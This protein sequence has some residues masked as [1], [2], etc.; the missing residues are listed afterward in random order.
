MDRRGAPPGVFAAHA[1]R[2]L[3]ELVR[4]I[5]ASLDDRASASERAQG[6]LRRMSEQGFCEDDDFPCNRARPAPLV[7][8]RRQGQPLS[9]ALV[10]M[11]L[12]RRLDIPLVGVNFPGR[13][14]LRVRSRPSARPGHRT[15]PLSH[16]LPRTAAALQGPKSELQAAYLKQASPGKILQRLSRN[17]RQLHSAAGERCRAEGCPAV[18]ELGPVGAADHEARA[19]LYRPTG[20]PA[21]GTLRPGARALA[22]D[23]PTEATAPRPAPGELARRRAAPCTEAAQASRPRPCPRTAWSDGHPSLR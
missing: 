8:Q 7:L 14:L 21:G 19:G 3:D 23:D 2:E 5:G 10:A 6:L 13:F 12:A 9:L 4:Q 18:I 1:L 11:E 20:L 16:R 22:S 15:A 17:L